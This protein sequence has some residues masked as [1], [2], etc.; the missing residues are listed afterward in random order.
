MGFFGFGVKTPLDNSPLSSGVLTPNPKKTQNCVGD[1]AISGRQIWT[2]VQIY[3]PQ[4]FGR[5]PSAFGRN[6]TKGFRKNGVSKI[7]GWSTFGV[8]PLWGL[9]PPE[10]PHA[11]SLHAS[12][13]AP[14]KRAQSFGKAV[15]KSMRALPSSPRKKILVVA[16]LAHRV[17][18]KI[19][20]QVERKMSERPNVL[21]EEIVDTVRQFYFRQDIV[22]TSPC[23][24]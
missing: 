24:L 19:A 1:L 10:A 17:G 13:T 16:E 15:R 7:G 21:E 5:P 12:A 14:Y 6:L 8:Y 11:S 9:H 2:K 23:L 4:I 20:N 3:T 18:L 22:Y